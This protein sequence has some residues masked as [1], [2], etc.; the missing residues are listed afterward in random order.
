MAGLV[1]QKVAANADEVYLV[2]SGL[3]VELKKIAVSLE[4]G[5]LNG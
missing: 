2:V 3:V 1:N 5:E 4:E